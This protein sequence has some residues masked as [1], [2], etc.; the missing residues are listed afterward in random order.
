MTFVILF[1][2]P[3]MIKLLTIH[4]DVRSRSKSISFASGCFFSNS[5]IS[6]GSQMVLVPI[7]LWS[8]STSMWSSCNVGT[9]S[10]RWDVPLLYLGVDVGDKVEERQ[11]TV[12]VEGPAVALVSTYVLG[13]VVV[14]Q[15]GGVV[16]TL[17]PE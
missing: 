11:G 10:A 1:I 14:R 17:R 9:V 7:S 16:A 8:T 2:P 6:S 15:Q 5:S 12:G 3:S 4:I 13:T